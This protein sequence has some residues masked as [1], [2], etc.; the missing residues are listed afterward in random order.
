MSVYPKPTG[1]SKMKFS[2]EVQEAHQSYERVALMMSDGGGEPKA[3]SGE[4]TLS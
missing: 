2:V 3:M 4:V 1:G